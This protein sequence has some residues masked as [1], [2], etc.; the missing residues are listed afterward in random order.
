MGIFGVSAPF[1]C[2]VCISH[3]SSCFTVDQVEELARYSMETVFVTITVLLAH[4]TVVA[5]KK[6]KSIFMAMFLLDFLLE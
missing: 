6:K 2:V 5:I 4:S 3:S 1:L